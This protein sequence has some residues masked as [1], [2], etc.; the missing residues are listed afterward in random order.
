M[1]QESSGKTSSFAARISLLQKAK[2]EPLKLA[3]CELSLILNR[4]MESNIDKQEEQALSL[5]VIHSLPGFLNGC[6][7]FA[8]SRTREEIKKKTESGQSTKTEKTLVGLFNLLGDEKGKNFSIAEKYW[9]YQRTM[10][11]ITSDYRRRDLSL[12]SLIE[13]LADQLSLQRVSSY[14]MK[15]IRLLGEITGRNISTTNLVWPEFSLT[16]LNKLVVVRLV[17]MAKEVVKCCLP[18][19]GNL[20]GKIVCEFE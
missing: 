8:V 15:E 19:D 20:S 17:A 11:P 9:L 5:A 13:K 1:Y 4:L 14:S 12:I 2:K 10:A 18:D 6:V 7:N 3:D 16:I